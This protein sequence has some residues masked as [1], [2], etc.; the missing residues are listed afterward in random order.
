MEIRGLHSEAEWPAGD[1][2]G[3]EGPRSPAVITDTRI[4]NNAKNKKPES[5]AAMTTYSLA[6]NPISGASCDE[7]ALREAPRPDPDKG[8]RPRARGEQY[9]T[10]RWLEPHSGFVARP[11]KNRTRAKRKLRKIGFI[12][13]YV[14]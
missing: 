7:V 1:N 9:L 10:E 5:K 6:K 11:E 13:S 8:V 14:R 12:R 4:A 3:N 2:N